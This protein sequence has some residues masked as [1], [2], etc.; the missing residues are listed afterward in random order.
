[1]VI[2]T[3]THCVASI[4]TDGWEPFVVEG[5]QA[6]EVAWLRQAQ[7]GDRP[8]VAG[9]WRALSGQLPETVPYVFHGHE[10][11]HVIEGE[12]TIAVDG[13]EPVR[14][15]P[16]DIASYTDGTKSTWTISTPFKKFFV[17]S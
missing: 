4:E 5:E 12:V 8:L 7:V 3:P 2:S 17:V 15:Q 6:G 10:T 1:M 16:G 14:L 9:V 11:F 13:E